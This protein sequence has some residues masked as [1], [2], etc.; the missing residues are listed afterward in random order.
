MKWRKNDWNFINHFFCLSFSPQSSPPSINTHQENTKCKDKTRV[1]GCL[2]VYICLR[3]CLR[4]CLL[5]LTDQ[6]L[7]K[8]E[9]KM[10][11]N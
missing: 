2:I 3:A 5:C 9:E 4:V 8:K 1:L 11:R 6:L 7:A 10:K